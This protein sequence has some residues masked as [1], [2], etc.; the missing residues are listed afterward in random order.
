MIAPPERSVS[1]QLLDESDGVVA[2]TADELARTVGVIC[3]P[4]PTAPFV[5]YPPSALEYAGLA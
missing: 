2:G 5:V 3:V 4:P 1:S